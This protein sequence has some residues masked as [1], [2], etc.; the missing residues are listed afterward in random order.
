M[1]HLH[2]CLH[3]HLHGSVTQALFVCY[4]QL[5][6]ENVWHFCLKRPQS[7]WLKLESCSFKVWSAKGRNV[8]TDLLH[9]YVDLQYPCYYSTLNMSS[10]YLC[11]LISLSNWVCFVRVNILMS[12]NCTTAKTGLI[13]CNLIMN[14][15]T[16]YTNCAPSIY[17]Y[18]HQSAQL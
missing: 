3:L 17:M 2:L 12:I 9:V 6:P 18:S 5:E 11:N 8:I 10:S 16:V 14:V 1:G 15:M 4:F 7:I 13:H